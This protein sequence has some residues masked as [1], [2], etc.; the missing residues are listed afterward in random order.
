MACMTNLLLCCLLLDTQA[1]ASDAPFEIVFGPKDPIPR[2]NG[3]IGSLEFM[4]L[5]AASAPWTQAAS[6][7]AVF[8]LYPQFITSASDEDLRTVFQDLKR[9]GI[10]IELA[11]GG[12][13]PTSTYGK[14]IE[15]FGAAKGPVLAQRIKDM[16]GTLA[17]V[18]LDEP[19]TFGCRYTGPRA[20]SMS[21]EQAAHEIVDYIRTM[22]AI[23]PAIEVGDAECLGGNA[24]HITVA[25]LESWLDTFR[26]INGAPFKFYTLDVV[27]TRAGALAEAHELQ[28]WVQSHG[29]QFGVIYD[30]DAQD[31]SDVEW[32]GHAEH[33][34]LQYE[35]MGG[36]RPDR[37]VMQSWHDHPQHLLP[38]SDPDSYTHLINA[39]LLPATTIDMR[40][41]ALTQALHY[42]V[43]GRI[44]SDHG[45]PVPSVSIA[46]FLSGD[47]PL[48]QQRPLGSAESLPD[49]SF[50]LEV[51]LPAKAT[52][53]IA[54]FAGD[55][56][57][58][59]AER[60][61]DIAR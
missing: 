41:H 8:K 47:K 22:K 13:M 17:Y 5:F 51:S 60:A 26:K 44:V 43:S 55:D 28:A 31:G 34:Y 32:L 19:Y 16:G 42:S 36:R 18:N 10:A 29:M 14:G 46:L 9:R 20:A 21:M 4:K 11:A 33:A 56:H 23:F 57:W 38:E 7:V 2:K 35:S 61:C 58:R 27:W 54:R 39:Y 3:K 15:G 25:D 45:A 24:G 53:V 40:T 30:G 1:C 37:I 6:H 49:G 59:P 12:L 48:P 50:S 52:Q